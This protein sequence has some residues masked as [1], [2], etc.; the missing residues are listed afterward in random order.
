[1]MLYPVILSGGT[2]S[3]LWP[4]SRAALPKQ[5]LPL[6]SERTLLQETVLRLHGLDEVASPAIICNQEH[7]FMIAEQLREINV[8]PHVLMLEPA[9]RD[10]AP[11]VAVAALHLIAHDPDALML[12]LPS[13]HAIADVAAFHAAI[14]QACRVAEQG[15]LVTFGI[16]PQGPMT[17]Y[18][19]IQRGAELET[20]SGAFA[21]A[22]FVEKPDLDTARKYVESGDYY[23]NSG[24]FLFSARCY[25]EELERFQPE[26]I[27]ACRASLEQ[28]Y[29]DLDFYRLGEDA[30]KTSP[31]S[32]IDYAV[33]EKTQRAAVIPVDIGWSDVGSW[34]ALWE[35]HP[36]DADGNVSYG[37]V[38]LHDV[39]NSYVNA[40][41]RLVAA[42]GVQDLIIV[43][44]PDAIL[45]AHK[46]HVQD[47]KKVVER[48]QK[49]GRTE[50]ETHRRCYRPWGSYEG[51]DQG[52]RFQVKRITVNPGAHLSLQMHHH[53]A[54]HWVV[55]SGT[56]QVT[57]GDEVRLV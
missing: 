19:Y 14:T 49:E 27:E 3:R 50:H 52:D 24:M 45:V 29:R 36:K 34:S 6:T 56:A 22:R 54:E 41:R 47:V 48:L 11:A 5:L 40:Q 12:V 44:T 28:A 43:E 37:E 53:R 42:V 8:T 9:G 1:M 39:H 17:G 4:M 21:V 33:M 15:Y 2:G 35:F 10:T 55:V 26:I 46:D 25:L 7:R 38:L 13:D 30:F 23:W 20:G 51:M 16:V 57:I 31:A 18:G 32:S